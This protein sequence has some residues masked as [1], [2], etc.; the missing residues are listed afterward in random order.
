VQREATNVTNGTRG[1]LVTLQTSDGPVRLYGLRW[2]REQ[3][4]GDP[5]RLPHTVKILLE[6]LLRRAGAAGVTEE[7]LSALARW[8]AGPPGNLSFMPARI[9][10][11]D[12]TGVP[13][14]VDLAGMRAAIVRA[15]GDP[16][17][18]DPQIPVDLVVDHSVQVDRFGDREAYAANIDWEYRRNGERYTLLRWAQH[19]FGALRV[20]PPGMGICHQVNLEY[21]SS[22]VRV[23]DGMALPDTLVGTDSHTTMVNG[24][25]VLGWGVG[26]IEAEAAMLGQPMF[27]PWPTVVGV[28]ISGRLPAGVNATD[29][30][31]TLTEALRAHGVVGAFV[32]FFGAGLSTLEVADR[33]TLSNMCPEYGATAALFPVDAGSLRYL[34]DTGRGRQVDLVERY[35]KEQGLF[36]TDPDPDPAFSEVLDLDLS[37][38]EPSLAGPKRPQDRVSLSGVWDSFV[39]A[40][41]DGAETGPDPTEVERFIAEGDTG[42]S[43]AE[44]VEGIES[45]AP[46]ARQAAHPGAEGLRD[47]S[48]VI[49][50][51]TSC[52]NTSNPFVMVSAGLLAQNAV[53][54]GLLTRP[55]VKTSLAPGSRVV[56]DYL[57]RAGLTPYLEKL[58]FAMVGYGCTTCIGNSGPL[59]EDDA[60]EVERRDLTVVAVLS[61]NRNFEGRI[62]PQ[63]RASY[64]ASPPLCVAYA[65]AGRTDLDLS[66]DALGEGAD[67]RP[68]YLRDIWPAAEEVRAI[69]DAA[70]TV[71]EFEREYGRIFEGDERW[72]EL[73]APSGAMYDWDPEST[74]VREPPFFEGVDGPPAP[75]ADIVDARVLVLFGDSVTTDHISP[76]GPIKADSPAGLYLIEQGVQPLEFNSYGSRRGNHEVMLRGTFGNPRLRNALTPDLEGPWTVHFPTGERTTIYDAAMRYSEEGVPL[77]VVAGKEYGSGSSRDW[78]AKGTALLGVR[79]VLAESFE[80]IHRSNLVALGVLPLQ[81]RSGDS[82]R[83]LGLSGAERLSVRGLAQGVRPGGELVVEARREDSSAVRFHAKVRIDGPVEVDYYYHGGVLPLVARQLLHRAGVGDQR[84]PQ[85]P[86]GASS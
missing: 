11:Q 15:G 22:I 42:I 5:Q 38:V 16:R 85:R 24:L 45:N 43:G 9:L 17:S 19:A 33:A 74:Y 59:P 84:H 80:R 53:N 1:A 30:V 61:G 75:L 18:V 7:D 64:L 8:P 28:R 51:I 62:H 47:G 70:V 57:E 20:V 14:V 79:S 55:W 27:L 10:L 78:A 3:G 60:R 12:F 29:L 67:G 4:L 72:R 52:T 48:V 82:A 2:L 86:T 31:L 39:A 41:R 65:L 66:R 44:A 46:Q 69:I 58:G 56:T 25:G 37:L 13:A 32:E 76:A 36:R 83:T 35:T 21:L 71:E 49:A 73:G 50:A 40:L 63:V 23:G 68:V 54:A 77:V 81:F 26:G 6:N 34:R